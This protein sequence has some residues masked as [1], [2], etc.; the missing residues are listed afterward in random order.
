MGSMM[1]KGGGGS[2]AATQQGF[3]QQ[4][5]SFLK[6][7]LRLA[8]AR[9]QPFFRAGRDQIPVLS[10]GSTMEGLDERLGDIFNTD[11]FSNLVGERTRAVQGQ[12][13]AGGLTRSGAGLQAAAAVPTDIGLAIEEMLTG[14]SRALANAGQTAITNLGQLGSNIGQSI[15]DLFNASGVAGAQG[16]AADGQAKA[17][18]TQ[19]LLTTAATVASMF[20]SDPKLKVNEEPIGQICDLKLYQW[21]WR[22]EFVDI[23]GEGFGTVGFMADEVKEKYPHRVGEH[24]GWMYID[25]PGLLEELETA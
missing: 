20:F 7:Q 1:G 21:D 13:S 22:P 10:H 18:G 24:A 12:L 5:I 23:M 4:G 17:Q 8:N 25:Y 3:N 11:T 6:K 9:L 15:A 2:G 19:Q 16:E 14:R